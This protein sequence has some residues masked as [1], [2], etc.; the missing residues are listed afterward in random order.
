[1]AHSLVRNAEANR[2]L[3]KPKPAFIVD[4]MLGS[5]AR[6]L[7]FFG[8]DAWYTKDTPDVEIILLGIK[9]CRVI[10]TCDRD[11]YKR[12]LKLRAK[13]TLLNGLSD[14]EDIAHAF[15]SYGTLLSTF[16]Y[17]RPRCPACNGTTVEVPR[18]CLREEIL[19]LGID[20]EF[21]R[22]CGCD[23]IYWEGSHY[24]CL[25]ALSKRIDGRI[26][27]ILKEP[28]LYTA[29][30]TTIPRLDFVSWRMYLP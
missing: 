30:H 4:S 21:F 5:V 26:L 2:L 7:R 6:K 9:H 10:L 23:K 18:S 27:E 14:L 15:F 3:V 16:M 17:V 12:A 1:M 24:R 19:G 28:S 29:D 13:G 22:C 11:M 8:F 25:K 20:S